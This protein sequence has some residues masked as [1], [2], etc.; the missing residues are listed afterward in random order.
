MANELVKK[1]KEQEYTIAGTLLLS[2][3]ATALMN[4]TAK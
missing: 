3:P 4:Q 2:V 1:R